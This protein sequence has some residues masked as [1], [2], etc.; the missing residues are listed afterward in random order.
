MYKK[1]RGENITPSINLRKN[2]MSINV[3]FKTKKHMIV[4][5]ME[6]SEQEH[7]LGS[8]S[9]NV[10]D[11]TLMCFKSDMYTLA[12]RLVSLNSELEVQETAYGD[13]DSPLTRLI[14]QSN[15]RITALTSADVDLGK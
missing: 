4:A 6:L 9:D 3:N 10:S 2:A 14:T 7:Y 12:K 5:S 1:H 11:S 15:D 13:V 8:I